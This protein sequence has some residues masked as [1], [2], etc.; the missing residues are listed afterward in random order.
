MSEPGRLSV[1]LICAQPERRDHFSTLLESSTVATLWKEVADWQQAAEL[2]DCEQADVVLWDIGTAEDERLDALRILTH[3]LSQATVFCVTDEL[4]PLSML[5]RWYQAGVYDVLSMDTLT[6]PWLDRTFSCA[7]GNRIWNKRISRITQ[8]CLDRCVD[9]IAWI[10]SDG[11]FCYANARFCQQIGYSLEELTKMAPWDIDPEYKRKDWDT[12]WNELREKKEVIFQS[13]H[14][15][16]RGRRF[17]VE[18]TATYLI[19]GGEEFSCVYVRD[20]SDTVELEK[21]LQ[22]FTAILDSTLEAIPISVFWKDNEGRYQG[23]NRL[24]LELAGLDD[25]SEIIGKKD[26]DLI[27][28]DDA[29][30]IKNC[31]NHIIATGEGINYELYFHQNGF[32][33]PRWISV[34][35]IPLKN[36]KG[37][38][39]GIV[40]A[41]QDVTER[42]EREEQLRRSEEKFKISFMDNPCLIGI[43]RLSDGTYLDINSTFE[44]VTGYSREEAIGKTSLELGLIDEPTREIYADRLRATGKIHD[45]EL[46]IQGKNGRPIE[47]LFSAERIHFNDEDCIIATVT[48]ITDYKRVLE[49]LRKSERLTEIGET[50]TGVAHYLKNICCNL[51]ASAELLDKAIEKGQHD[52]I[53]VFWNIARRSTQR[54]ETMSRDLLG[55]ARSFQLQ[56]K[57]CNMARVLKEVHEA[58]LDLAHDRHATLSL[59]CS[60]EKV[61]ADVDCQKIYDAILNLVQNALDACDESGGGE[62]RISIRTEHEQNLIIEVSDTGKRISNDVQERMFEPFYSTKGDQ[63]AGLGLAVTRKIIDAHGGELKFSQTGE[64]KVFGCILPLSEAS[65]CEC[66]D[67]H[68]QSGS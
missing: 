33:E 28:K 35:K 23:C 40:G 6:T 29:P 9:A 10:R 1:L 56:T 37:N 61:I 46:A 63:G 22:S 11:L 57:S 19:D 7:H 51:S 4:T 15:S 16:G 8:F 47:C 48:D 45:I 26:S 20:L 27:W 34:R 39:I 41:W 50:V 55:Y 32:G 38:V 5:P 18:I 42:N 21:Q 24:H 25:V 58:S 59:E 31:D 36:A 43:S 53:T 65:I 30:F 44:K 52:N 12:S 68:V 2:E 60:E 66:F 54:I 67:T 14:L 17:P 64:H 49:Q 3:R 62:V 13:V